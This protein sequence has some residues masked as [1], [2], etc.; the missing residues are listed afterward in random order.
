ML[1]SAR[2]RSPCQF[3]R[4]IETVSLAPGRVATPKRNQ[5]LLSAITKLL[6]VS[7]ALSAPSGRAVLSVSFC[8]KISSASAAAC[9]DGP[10][11]SATAPPTAPASK[12][13][14]SSGS[15]RNFRDLPHRCGF[16]L[17]QN[18]K[19]PLNDHPPLRPARSVAL[20]RTF[21]LQQLAD[22]RVLF[23]TAGLAVSEIWDPSLQISSHFQQK[24]RFCS[25]GSPGPFLLAVSRDIVSRN[26][27][28]P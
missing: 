7:G 3:C 20:T 11:L 8:S 26:I 21:M 22:T 5:S 6:M 18:E 2:S 15:T 12:L 24:L 4:L 19:S 1:Y 17:R 28:D 25:R 16:G 27:N 14:S 10:S 23:P 9:P 13:R